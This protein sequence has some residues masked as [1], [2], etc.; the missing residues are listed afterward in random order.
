MKLT[1]STA[2][3]LNDYLDYLPRHKKRGCYECPVCNGK[4]GISRSN[5]EKFTCFAGCSHSDI[6]KAILALT[7]GNTQSEEFEAAR[8]ARATRADEK[9]AAETARI[10]RLKNSDERERD[11]QG[12]IKGTFLTDVHRQDMLE[13]GYTPELIEK[14]N[15]RSSARHGGGRVIP[16]LDYQGRMVGGQVITAD[17]KP[18][19]GEAGTN[20]LQETGEIPLTVIYPDR[21][22]EGTRKDKATGEIK[23]VGYIAYTESTGDKPFLCANLHDYVTVGSSNVGSQPNDLK[24]TIEGI[25]S[26]MGWDEVHHI[27]MADAGSLDNN[28]VM[29]N[30]RNLNQQIVALG[31]LLEVGWWGQYT[32]SIGDI[33]EISKDTPLRYIPFDRFD[34]FGE[35]RKLYDALSKLNIKPTTTINQRFLSEV[36][37]KPNTIIFVDSPCATGK[38]HILRPEIEEWTE[39]YPDGRVIDITHLNSIKSGHQERLGISEYRVGHG[40]NDAAINGLSKISICVDSL[41]RL[42]LENIPPHSL[43]ILDEME[44]ILTHA[45]QG[46]TLGDKAAN[47]QAHLTAI[48]DRVLVTGGAVVGLEDSLTDIS[49][50]G[51]LDLTGNRY[52]YELVKNEYQPYQWD[53]AI[54]NGNNADFLGTLLDRLKAGQ[55]IFFP[56]SSQNYGEAVHKLVLKHL[57]ELA[58]KICRADAKTSSELQQLFANPNKWLAERDLRLFIGSSTIQS[59]FNSSN[60]GQFNRVMGRFANLDTRSHVQHLH[61]DRSDVPRDIFVL[62]KGAEISSQKNPTKLLRSR[63]LIANQTSLAA[64]HGRIQNN[65][66]GDVWNRLDA[67]FSARA[68]LSTAYLEDYLR[69]DLAERGHKISP[70]NWQPS[71]QFPGIAED[72]K[73]IRQEIKVEEN[74]IMFV[75]DGHALSPVQALSILH[76]SGVPFETRQQAKKTLL[77][78]DLPGAELTEEFLMEAVTKGRGAYLSQCKLGFFLEQPALAKFLDRERF[79]GQLAQPHIMYSKVPKLGQK[80]DL[81]TPIH[82]Y[83]IDLASGREFK[84]NDPAVLAIQAFALEHTYL[85]WALFGLIIEPEDIRSDGKRKNSA[86]ATTSKILKKLGHRTEEK[87]KEGNRGEQVKI[88]EVKACEYKQTIHQALERKYKEYLVI[89]SLDELISTN[90]NLDPPLGIMDTGCKQGEDPPI[91]PIPEDDPP[92]DFQV[93]DIVEIRST[94]IRGTIE[95]WNRKGQASILSDDEVFHSWIPKSNLKLIKNRDSA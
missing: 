10:A 13:R 29:G 91:P 59:G 72:F 90:P 51:L 25:K 61:R 35:D 71:E 30:Y 27:L 23:K 43:L 34:K 14:S 93:G 17:G 70:A 86:F 2:L 53:V 84:D 24:R 9:L 8:A 57:P 5:G 88:Y 67:E 60:E 18:W 41:L 11:W 42:Q 15:A 31:G 75:A 65:R 54:G 58:D 69:C 44:A 4:L 36:T 52:K 79:T 26:R 92:P 74:R 33:D 28:H 46:N 37:L 73:A 3:D 87:R 6:R 7:G 50:R 21:P 1:K 12:I 78:H 20:Q 85:M 22:R 89:D 55:K 94:G 19:Y 66:V 32:K 80:I 81:L 64:G 63:E 95:I 39:K 38:T 82:A 45:A 49:V 62:N 56:T 40:Q 48:I 83:L 77:H 76:S 68:A 47:L 16:I